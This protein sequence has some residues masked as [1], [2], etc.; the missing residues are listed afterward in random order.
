MR[1]VKWLFVVVL[2]VLGSGIHA[3][4]V[5]NPEKPA[6]QDA[7][8]IV[9]IT[10]VL[11][12][13]DDGKSY[14]FKSPYIIKVAPDGS[15]FVADEEQLLQFDKD[16]KFVRNHQKKGEGPGECL[17][18]SNFQIIGDHL[19]VVSPVPSKILEFDLSGKLIKENR[20]QTIINLF[21]KIL[22]IKKDM[23]YSLYGDFKPGELKAGLIDF[24]QNIFVS[25]FAGKPKDLNL[26]FP[27]RRRLVIVKAGNN[28]TMTMIR[29]IDFFCYNVENENSLYVSHTQKYL[30]KHVDMANGKLLGE[31]R[32]PY[33]SVPYIQDAT[34]K[35]YPEV[36]PREFFPDVEQI[37]MYKG[38]VWV[39]TSTLDNQKGIL[40]DV[41]SKE[42]K[43]LD[44]FYL[45][46]PMVTRP[47]VFEKNPL[48]VWEDF[49]FAAQRD[50]DENFSIVKYK[51]EI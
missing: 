21:P 28:R 23:Y 45:P 7:G 30:V 17:F 27:I 19:F 29:D 3:Q 35:K 38:K 1:F 50:E 16:G 8:R 39:F 9:K 49:I 31:F 20:G 46:F 40:V 51:I 11:R 25:T 42:G 47:D 18:I 37:A 22:D 12:I 36:I 4:I 10:T 41:F 6:A 5:N 14:F 2:M 24:K 34:D 43:Y 48:F 32:R 44:N 13:L 33:N 26:S 15:I